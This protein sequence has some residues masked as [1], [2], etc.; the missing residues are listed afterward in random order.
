MNPTY[1]TRRKIETDLFLR[2]R[3]MNALHR[4]RASSSHVASSV[5]ATVQIQEGTSFIISVKRSVNRNVV[6]LLF[7]TLISASYFIFHGRPKGFSSA[8]ET[9]DEFGATGACHGCRTGPGASLENVR[10]VDGKEFAVIMLGEKDEQTKKVE[11][12]YQ[13]IITSYRNTYIH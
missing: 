7:S 8:G 10:L 6:V 12:F 11:I 5:A 2:L 1:Q 4:V 13:T 9:V 3:P